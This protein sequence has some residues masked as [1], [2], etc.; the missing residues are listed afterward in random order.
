MN[1][2]QEERELRY[3]DRGPHSF[4]TSTGRL[5]T[6]GGS[7]LTYDMYQPRKSEVT[8]PLLLAHGFAR[9]R[10]NMAGMA[11]H[12][13]RWGLTIVNI[14]LYHL[15]P[16][17]INHHQNGADLAELADHLGFNEVVFA[18]FSAGALAS[19]I[20]GA[21]SRAAVGVLA[22]DPVDFGTV[23][24]Q[25]AR[26]LPVPLYSIFAEL[27]TSNAIF[28]GMPIIEAT[29]RARA[30]RIV[31]ASH[32]F[33]EFPTN[34]ICRLLFHDRLKIFT[35]TQIKGAILETTTATA[36]RLATTRQ[37]DPREW[38]PHPCL[39]ENRQVKILL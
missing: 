7:R 35:P 27:T 38:E 34:I 31:E 13:A 11:V 14:D 37:A 26:Q 25:A 19:V 21:H 23:G 4:R 22:L 18:G 33:F 29:S 24:Q 3:R 8:T 12:M 16:W 30:I 39:L 6:S 17:R 1:I 20:A 2:V 10:Q 5:T 28:K 15:R 32:C 36:M 9:R